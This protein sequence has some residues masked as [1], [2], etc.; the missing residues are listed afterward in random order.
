MS[1]VKISELV[2][3]PSIAANTSN[4]IF[5]GVDVPTR[6]TGKFTAT[7]LAQQLFANNYLVVGQNYQTIFPNTVG[8]ISG[9]DPGFLQVNLQNFGSTGSADYVITA[10]T[11]TNANSY[12]DMGINN[13]NYSDP[14]FSSMSPYDGYLYVHGPSDT[15]SQGNLILGAF[16]SNAN[17][18]FVAGGTQKSNITVTISNTAL[19]LD[20]S[21]RL[22]FGDG[23]IQTTAAVGN[24]YSQASYALANTNA[25]DIVL[26][27]STNAIQ[28]ANISTVV[29]QSQASFDYANTNISYITGV[30][31][32]QNV[33]SSAAFAKANAALAN[34]SGTFAGDLTI[35]GNI[36][37][38]SISTS[39]LV[40]FI[41]TG[42][43]TTNALVEII[44]SDG[45]TQQTP[46]NDGY[47]LHITGKANTPARLIV[48]AFGANSYAVIAGRSGRGTAASPQA[49]SNNDILMRISGNGWG[50]TGFAPLGS[51]RIDI[52]A[53]ENFTDTARGSRIKFY[54]VANGSNTITEI[55]SF[56][57]NSVEFTGS[58]NPQKGF[59]YTP[60]LPAGNQTAITID[61]GN[62]SIIKANLVADLTISHT[63]FTS[64]KIVEVWL[65]N[66][67][68]QNRTV[69]HGLSAINSTSKSTTFTISATSSAYLRFFSID[70]DLAS[71]F[72]TVTA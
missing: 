67:G 54:N 52:V 34:A 18:Y 49:V 46:S 10:D 6:I 41:G 66:S 28:N 57:A 26:I 17:I 32:Y 22:V 70:G 44:G 56:N 63:N 47:M 36:T 12:I 31:L 71:T 69:T 5:L 8:Q 51:G 29:T 4:T 9:T 58:V 53:A 3:L 48:D 27:K 61:Y 20:T 65:V 59:V 15:S 38:R 25:A 39:N 21:T 14:N 55:A 33:Y 45:G 16:S 62:D 37:A 42:T 72:V 1:T 64:G 50:T 11:G 7:T 60:R 2:N 24:N 68:A 19:V 43:P 30:N 13:S 35:T 23:T 40:S